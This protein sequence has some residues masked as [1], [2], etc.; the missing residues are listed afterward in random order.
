MGHR[1]PTFH[2]DFDSHHQSTDS[3]SVY[4]SSIFLPNDYRMD[5]HPF[6]KCNPMALGKHR[7]YSLPF[8]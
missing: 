1:Y 6:V 4:L 8:H 2:P 7:L 3:L 5:H